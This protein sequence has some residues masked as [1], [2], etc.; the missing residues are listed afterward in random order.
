MFCSLGSTTM[1][2]IAAA[3]P[4]KAKHTT[5]VAKNASTIKSDCM[6]CS[7]GSMATIFLFVCGL[8]KEQ[9][10]QVFSL[11]LAFLG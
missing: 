4:K 2:T 6:L 7:L 8:P 10:P 11:S 3:L 9:N 1:S 5:T